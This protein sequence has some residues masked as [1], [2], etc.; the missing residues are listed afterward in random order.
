MTS[1]THRCPGSLQAINLCV[2]I[3]EIEVP[4]RVEEKRRYLAGVS[5]FVSWDEACRV[6]RHK[7]TQPVLPTIQRKYLHVLP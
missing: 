2:A 4:S 5:D 6:P 1:V 7:I 3:P